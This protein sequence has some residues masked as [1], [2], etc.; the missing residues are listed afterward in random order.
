MARDRHLATAIWR[1]NYRKARLWLASLAR[2]AP[3]D[4]DLLGEDARDSGQ[5]R[6]IAGCRIL[7]PQHIAGL[8]MH[9]AT[10][11]TGLRVAVSVN[12]RMPSEL[13]RGA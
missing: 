9:N 1:G 3:G 2:Q 8:L 13:K 4:P 7:R 5:N 6:R 12:S 11:A 10:V